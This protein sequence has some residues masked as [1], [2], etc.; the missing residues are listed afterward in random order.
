[1][2]ECVVFREGG[3]GERARAYMQAVGVSVRVELFTWQ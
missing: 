2:S 1:M 3:E